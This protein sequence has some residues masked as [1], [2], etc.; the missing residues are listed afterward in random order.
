MEDLTL[1]QEIAKKMFDLFFMR[2]WRSA[3]N[4]VLT[5]LKYFYDEYIAHIVHK[6]CP[7][8]YC[9]E[10]LTYTVN[11]N[12]IGCTACARRCPVTAISGEKKARHL[13]DQLKCIKCG[14][15]Y[16]TCKFNAID[17]E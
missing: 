3:P 10:L 15:C 4:P 5:T 8:K 6:K 9:K 2:P 12:C 14:A 16:A 1:L 11:E 7:A 13:I 17:I